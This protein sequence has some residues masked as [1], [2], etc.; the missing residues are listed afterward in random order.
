MNND[1]LFEELKNGNSNRVNF[2]KMKIKEELTKRKKKIDDDVVNRILSDAI[3][4]YDK[5]IPFLF[6]LKALIKNKYDKKREIKSVKNKFFNDKEYQIIEYYLK[7]EDGRYYTNN[8]IA[9]N[10]KYSIVDVSETLDRFFYIMK[11]EREEILKIFPTL[12]KDLKK[13]ESFFTKESIKARKGLKEEKKEKNRKKHNGLLSESN[14]RI[15]KTLNTYDY[16]LEELAIIAGYKSVNSFQAA[17]SV[18][19]KKLKNN[20]KML[21]EAKKYYRDIDLDSETINTKRRKLTDND[22]AILKLMSKYHSVNIPCKE[23]GKDKGMYQKRKSDLLRKLEQDESLLEEAKQYYS[24]ITLDKPLLNDTYIQILK[25]FNDP[26]L[27]TKSIADIVKFT[28]F[29]NI[30]I[31]KYHLKRLK[32]KLKDEEFKDKCIKTYKEYENAIKYLLYPKEILFHSSEI[33][34]LKEYLDYKP[35]KTSTIDKVKQEL[36]EGIDLDIILWDNFTMNF[37]IRDNFNPDNSINI[38]HD[39][40]DNIKN[41]KNTSDDLLLGIKRLEESIFKDYISTCT[42]KEKYILALRLGYYNKRSF[43][44]SEVA[45]IFSIDESEVI[46]LTKE[47]LNYSKNLIEE[48]KILRKKLS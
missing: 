48:K 27:R 18:L 14:I 9:I 22:I 6:H 35:A 44:S 36:N 17:K 41:V 11:N 43:S 31:F 28:N 23:F 4:S 25:A 37:I 29:D 13:R 8:N 38:S 40:L 39:E 2:F 20:E 42:L 10:L 45:D 24:D 46:S 7:G 16:S 47:C 1:N 34:S 5:T 21:E 33:K 30:Y 12:D 32:E 19:F 26:N 3:A 15:L